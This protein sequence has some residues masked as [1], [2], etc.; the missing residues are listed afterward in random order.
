MID[1][2]NI[3]VRF[4]I[5]DSTITALSSVSLHINK[6]EYVAM[7]GPNGS[8]KSTLV[9]A[10][11]GM[12]QPVDG[13]I[14]L[15]DRELRVGKFGE[16]FFGDVGVVFQEPE[17]QFLMP[18]VKR[19]IEA[20]LQ[21]LGLHQQQQKKQ[22]DGIVEL[23]QLRDILTKK[24]ENLAGG[25]MQIVNLACALATHPQILILD[26]PTTFLDPY[27][28]CILMSYIKHFHKNGMTILHVTQFPDET[29][30]CS[31]ICIIDKGKFVFNGD[32]QTISK[33]ADI[34]WEH[35]LGL[36][37]AQKLKNTFKTFEMD[38]KRGAISHLKGKTLKSQLDLELNA[39]RSAPLLSMGNVKY[40]YPKSNFVLSIEKLELFKGEIVGIIG[41]TGSGKSTLAYLL[42]GLYEPDSGQ[43]YY[44]D[45]RLTEY[46]ID[47]LRR[48]IGITW[49]L[50]DM[51]MIGP[52]VK[53]DIEFGISNLGIQSCDIGPLLMQVGLERFENRIVDTLSGGEKRKLSI[54]GIL[55]TNPSYLIL[56]EPAAFLD[57]ISQYELT[58][59][60]QAIGKD[61]TG[62]LVIAHNMRFLGGFA[63]RIVAL[64]SGSIRFDIP[65]YDFFTNLQYREDLWPGLK[66]SAEP[67]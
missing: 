17:G 8:G 15:L 29:D 2:D 62:I 56:D 35:R 31:R 38:E 53:E 50:P 48:A 30:N 20:V 6:G 45:K 18:T 5:A 11:C 54:A 67:R 58:E 34:L 57:P 13:K 43:I 42:S 7:L 9:K 65:A 21:N 10:L 33:K 37:R 66:R 60:I 47:E 4:K 23:F 32:M 52:T 61:G 55:A 36:S 49:Q 44:Q 26:E 14:K 40:S 24:P 39:N 25:Q 3:T 41:P 12:V 16:D 63:D 27:Y 51:A 28:R 22:F 64:E 59:I 1:I 19:E 46:P